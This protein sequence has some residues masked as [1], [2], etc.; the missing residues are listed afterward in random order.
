MS[1]KLP[2]Y[3]LTKREKALLKRVNSRFARC[4]EIRAVIED[5]GGPSDARLAELVLIF[6]LL[7]A[8][9]NSS[10]AVRRYPEND[11][12]EFHETFSATLRHVDKCISL[13]SERIKK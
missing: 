6:D 7:T 12:K 13:I 4:G 5:T 11:L 1:L 9:R 10:S 3:R 2:E 8:L